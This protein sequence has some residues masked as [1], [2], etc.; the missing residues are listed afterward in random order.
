MMR[1]AC[2]AV[3][4]CLVAIS[5]AFAADWPAYYGDADR[6]GVAGEAL[7]TPLHPAWQYRAAHEPSPAFREGLSYWLEERG[8]DPV[9]SITY[10][11]AYHPVIADDRLYFGSSTEEALFCLDADTGET[12]WRYQVEGAVRHAPTVWRG[13]VYFGSDDGFVYCLEGDSGALR[14]RLHAAPSERRCIGNERIISAWP[15]RTTVNI[16]RDGREAVAYFGAGLFPPLGVYLCAADPVTGRLLW[17]RQVPYSLQGQ[18]LC[19]GHNLLVGTGR[20]APAEFRRDDGAP[21]VDHPPLRRCLGSGFIRRLGGVAAWGPSEGGSFDLR[22]RRPETRSDRGAGATVA[23]TVI[24]LRARAVLSSGRTVYVLADRELL[25]VDKEAFLAAAGEVAAGF[26]GGLWGWTGGGAF[27]H[28]CSPAFYRSVQERADWSVPNERGLR[29]LIV[30][31]DVLFAGGPDIV[32][33]IDRRKGR[34]LWS[35]AVG[36]TAF[37]LAVADGALFVST[38]RGRLYCFRP[39]RATCIR[40]SC[41]TPSWLRPAASTDAC[42]GLHRRYSAPVSPALSSLPSAPSRGLGPTE[43]VLQQRPSENFPRVT[44]PPVPD[45]A[46][47]AAVQVALDSSRLHR[48]YCVVVGA[49]DGAAAAEIAHRSGFF[50]LVLEPDQK[51]VR[52][53]RENLAR[54]GLYGERAVVHHVAGP[55]LHYARYFANVLIWSPGVRTPYSPAA[56]LRLL[57]PCGGVAV[58]RA[59]GPTGGAGDWSAEALGP[60]ERVTGPRGATWLVAERGRLPGAGEWTHLYADAGNTVCSDDERVGTEH[61]PQW[62]GPPGPRDVVE[63]HSLAHAPLYKNGTLYVPGL[64]HTVRAVDAYNGTVLWKLKVAESTRKGI[65]HNAGYMAATDDRLYIAGGPTCRAADASTGEVAHTFR[66]TKPDRDWGYVAAP[67]D[68]LLGSSQ[69]PAVGQISYNH[70]RTL[71][72]ARRLESRPT[73]SED[74]FAYD[75][76]THKRKWVYENRSAI[77]N[78]TI[79]AGGGRVYF[80]ESRSPTVVGEPTGTVTLSDFFAQGAELVALDLRAGRASWRVPLK[81]LSDLPGDDH[82]HIMF[83]SFSDGLLVST[84]TGHVGGVLAYVLTVRDAAT[85]EVRWRDVVRSQHAVYAPL[86]YGKNMQQAH[87]SIVNGRIHWLA[88]TFGTVFGHDLLTGEQGNDAGFGTG[89]QNKGCAPPTASA[90][91]LYYRNTTSYMYDLATRRKISL[92]GVTRPSCWMSILPVGGLVLMPEASSGCTC[93]FALQTSVALA[94]VHGGGQ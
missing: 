83:L 64:L 88:H 41:R 40:R 10:D 74:L 37:G 42:V 68:L 20:T 15:V 54:A 94:P 32:V 85:G 23:G 76:E 6:T 50:V 92:T 29:S 87:P 38:D 57:R 78:P 31:G 13:S 86:S 24:G 33:A 62:C 72:F 4:V 90:S 58:R 2:T 35:H 11:Y 44:E 21:L 63:R 73:V 46:C 1:T 93:G 5:A 59:P 55:D 16:M 22:I 80:A 71:Y 28:Q 53:A 79:T 70:L 84:R 8:Q 36:G 51:R 91:G 45:P 60:W 34:E 75:R 82:E 49:Q 61:A 77:L 30:A 66:C 48:G 39:Q 25:A 47:R 43:R 69:R 14:W 19:D 65:S 17:R 26:K 67:G 3:F 12:L 9:E 7:S 56:V 52:R 89:W 81:P 27:R 18:I